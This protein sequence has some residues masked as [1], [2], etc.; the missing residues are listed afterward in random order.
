VTPDDF[1]GFVLQMQRL[2]AAFKP[3]SESAQKIYFQALGDL[4]I[5]EVRVAVG[6]AV[7]ELRSRPVPA[8]LRDLVFGTPQQ[9]EALAWAAVKRLLEWP[10]MLR[11]IHLRLCDAPLIVAAV[12]TMGG[13]EDLEGLTTFKSTREEFLQAYREVVS[14]AASGRLRHTWTSRAGSQRDSAPG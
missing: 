11:D 8:V 14:L 10:P 12:M 9:R 13:W 6:R 5:E 1:P 4:T 3:L 7:S 2:N